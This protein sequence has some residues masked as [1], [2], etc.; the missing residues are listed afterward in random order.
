MR[1]QI[2]GQD[3]LICFMVKNGEPHLDLFVIDKQ[4]SIQNNAEMHMSLQYVT[5]PSEDLISF[6]LRSNDYFVDQFMDFFE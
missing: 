6:F 5:L 2:H 4:I 1:P 3:K